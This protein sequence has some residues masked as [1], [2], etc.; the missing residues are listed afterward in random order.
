MIRSSLEVL[1]HGW[2]EQRLYLAGVEAVGVEEDNEETEAGGLV[3][4]QL[5]RKKVSNNCHNSVQVIH[6]EIQNFQQKKT[7]KSQIFQKN[8]NP[9]FFSK[10]LTFSQIFNMHAHI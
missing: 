2:W 8:E 5:M 7:K 4:N 9:N 1:L 10:N 3:L 6:R